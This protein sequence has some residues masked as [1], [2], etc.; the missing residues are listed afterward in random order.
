MLQSSTISFN[1]TKDLTISFIAYLFI[2]LLNA[3]QKSKNDDRLMCLTL[4]HESLNQPTSDSV[5]QKMDLS[6]FAHNFV[7]IDR[8]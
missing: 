7:D 4:Q 1:L 5:S 6:T 8:F 3:E 2:C